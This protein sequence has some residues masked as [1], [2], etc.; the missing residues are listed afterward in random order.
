[1]KE[2][3]PLIRKPSRFCS[4]CGAKLDQSTKIHCE[5]RGDPRRP[6]RFKDLAIGEDFIS[7][8][9]RR[10]YKSMVYGGRIPSRFVKLDWLRAVEVGSGET[11]VFSGS[12][13]VIRISQAPGAPISPRAKSLIDERKRY[14]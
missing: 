1:M 13:R 4:I 14:D 12:S 11:E 2:N 9:G 5:L 6:D 7:M 8:Q 3:S 10:G